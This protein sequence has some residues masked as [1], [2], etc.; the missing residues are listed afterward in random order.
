MISVRS[1]GGT[2][3]LAICKWPGFNSSLEARFCLTTSLGTSI[4]NSKLSKNLSSSIAKAVVPLGLPET[5][6]GTLISAL[7][8]H[9]NST[10]LLAEVRGI[11]P[12]IIVAGAYG[13]RQGYA[14]TFQYLWI[15]GVC[16]TFVGAVGTYF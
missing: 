11:T 2:I 13:L 12:D 7:L 15:T 8:R 1:L 16:F 3:G 9:D 10:E 4:F 14:D 5:S 6:L